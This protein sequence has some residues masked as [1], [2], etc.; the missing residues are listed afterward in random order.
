MADGL[1]AAVSNNGVAVG[2]LLNQESVWYEEADQILT[3]YK[4][5]TIET[6]STKT[7]VSCPDCTF[8]PSPPSGLLP[9]QSGEVLLAVSGGSALIDNVVVEVLLEDFPGLVNGQKYL[10][11]MNLNPS[12]QIA[13]VI[14]PQGIV[15]VNSDNTFAPVIRLTPGATEPIINGLA[16]Q[17]GNSLVQLRA[18]LNPPSLYFR[19]TSF[20]NPSS[21]LCVLH[22]V[23][24]S[25]AFA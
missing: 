16:T 5:R 18:V 25:Q 9:L 15:H 11:F 21:R 14:A 10:L 6:L 24:V 2:E 7:Y 1:D 3:W 17:Y 20:S 19:T 12:S 23:S 4:F 8:D 13:E 22:R